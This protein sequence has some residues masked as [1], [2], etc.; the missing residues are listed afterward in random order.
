MSS[1]VYRERFF[2]QQWVLLRKS[3]KDCKKHIK[4]PLAV[5]NEITDATDSFIY[6][7]QVG[8]LASKNQHYQSKIRL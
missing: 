6:T 4:S 7:F 8:N 1:T 3:Q 5:L 2:Y